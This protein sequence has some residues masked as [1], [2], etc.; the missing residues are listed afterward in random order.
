MAR[1]TACIVGRVSVAPP[2]NITIQR[3]SPDKALCAAIRESGAVFIPGG[4]ALTGATC[5]MARGAA[6]IVGRVSVAPPDNITIQ[7]GS[8]DKALCA[9]I[10]ESGAVFI[11]GGAALTGATCL[12]AR[13]AACIVGRVS[14]A[15]PD[16]IT[17]QRGSPDKALCAVIREI[18]AVII[19]G[20]AALTG[21]TCL[22][23][24]RTACIVG[25][26]SVAPPDNIT[27]QRGSPDKAL[28]ASI[29]KIGAVI[30]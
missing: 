2:D 29:R 26:V 9:A 3:G 5:L 12:M 15:P 16:N 13:G 8:P 25:R 10:R 28:C 14:V 21:A 4:A 24:R 20:G 27:I 11:P 30:S 22:M 7:R 23:A 17:I 19:P 1:G 18:G 6:C